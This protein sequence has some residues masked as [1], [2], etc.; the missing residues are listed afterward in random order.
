MGD[1]HAPEFAAATGRGTAGSEEGSYGEGDGSEQA[2]PAERH[3]RK[4]REKQATPA[5][6]QIS[7]QGRIRTGDTTIFSRVLY[8]LSYL[9]TQCKQIQAC[10]ARS[11]LRAMQG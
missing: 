7:G 2:E 8:Q 5:R 10:Y 3:R 9:A 6:A 11:C 4:D 1:D